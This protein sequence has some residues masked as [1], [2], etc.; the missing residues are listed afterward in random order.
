MKKIILLIPLLLLASC[1]GYHS[2]YVTTS[3]ETPSK[4]LFFEKDISYDEV[5]CS[6][7]FISVPAQIV[8]KNVFKDDKV[9]AIMESLD[10]LSYQEIG[11]EEYTIYGGIGDTYVFSNP[12]AATKI[13]NIYNNDYQKDDKF[14]DLSSGITLP[15]P[16]EV[17]YEFDMITTSLDSYYK[18]GELL[19]TIDGWYDGFRFEESEFTFDEPNYVIDSYYFGEIKCYDGTHFTL[20]DTGIYYELTS[21]ASFPLPL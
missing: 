3:S 20:N 7:Y 15:E 18:N 14:Y 11:R 5:V 17:Y 13:I 10:K 1:G 6:S 2:S 9:S 8:T 21:L 12:F 19:Y 16:D 4:S